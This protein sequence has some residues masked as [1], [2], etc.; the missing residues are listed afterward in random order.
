MSV[1]NMNTAEWKLFS[2]YKLKG[3]V[4][5]NRFVRAAMELCMADPDG[6]V[7]EDNINL[8]KKAVEGGIGLFITE[9]TCV[10]PLGRFLP[11]Q[12][13]VYGDEY[14]PGLEKLVN[15]MHA[16]GDGVVA[17][18]QLHA[19]GAKAW[20]YSYGQMDTSLGLDIIKEET[21]E[22]IVNAFGD[23]ALRIRKAGFDGVELHGGHGY[24]IS[25]FLSPAVN[26]RKDKWGGSLENRARFPLALYENIREKAGDD[27]SI[28]IKVNTADYLKGGHWVNDTAQIANKF[29]EAGFDFIEMSGGMGFMT[30]LREELRKKVGEKEYYFRDA[31][32]QFVEAVKGTNTALIVVGGMG[33][34]QVMEEILHE[35]VDFIS[36]ARPLLSEPDFPNRVKAGDLRQVRCVSRQHLCNLCLTK[37]AFGSATCIKFFPG[38]CVMTCPIEQDNPTYFTLIAQRKFEDAL[39]VVK[40]DNPLAG[41][42][43]RVCRHPC[44]TICRGET[45]EPLAIMNLKRFIT[46]YG[47]RNGLMVKAKPLVKGGRGKVAIIGSGPA[48][49]TCGFYLAQKGYNPTIFEK[50]SVKGGMIATG[51]PRYR[52]PEK[53]LKA[54]IDYVE[55]IGVEIKTGTALGEDF[56]IKDLFAQGY[57]AVFLAAGQ[58]LS[59]KLDIEGSDLDGVLLGLDFLRDV[60]LGKKVKIG[61]RVV[62]I[63]G[64]NVAIDVAMATL[65]LGAEEVRVACLESSQEM[66]AYKWEIDDALEEG[67]IL[68]CCWGPKRIKGNGKV[69][70]VDFVKCTSVFDKKG[71]FNPKFNEKTKMSLDADTV[72]IAIGQAS[73]LASLNKESGI[74]STALET[75]EVDSQTLQT[76][77]PGVFA[78]GDVV[79][80]PSSVVDAVAAGKTAAESID[81]FIQG[82]GLVREKDYGPFVKITRPSAFADPSECVLKENSLRAV[83]PRLSV[84]ER[85]G[86]F[87]EI[88]GGLS[89]EQAVREAKRCLKY[90]LELE[91]KSRAKMAHMGKATFVLKP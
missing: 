37:V 1:T 40:K 47:L 35:G 28:G 68:N 80:G 79:T 14:I 60:N 26:Q 45:G 24:L 8:H 81:R 90:D 49:L 31:I 13:V 25:Q 32:P 73:D 53:V 43:S 36:L 41:V 51:I 19:G 62:V 75:I 30:Q 61:K 72:I 78:G 50:L 42:L 17:F 83:P 18:A 70:G 76:A 63:G 52:L 67:V 64:G 44:E 15:V 9:S 84:A 34:P 11:N 85:R 10:H 71:K 82:R 65:R 56:S 7:T 88:V 59:R 89:E 20:G 39:A 77:L 69:G 6:F 23:A 86:T 33:T 55:S 48:G 91:E 38:D 5:K 54:D 87:K 57:K 74:K 3:L 22:I 2:P 27:F 21:I 66:P 46:D 4:I 12:L 16:H 58:P 29:A